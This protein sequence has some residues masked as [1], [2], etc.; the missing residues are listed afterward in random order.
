MCNSLGNRVVEELSGGSLLAE[1]EGSFL[2]P[3][4]SCLLRLF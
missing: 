4:L 3:T 1:V 2:L